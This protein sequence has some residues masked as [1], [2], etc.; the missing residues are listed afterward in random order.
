MFNAIIYSELNLQQLEGTASN[1][2][3][4]ALAPFPL[5]FHQH[6]LRFYLGLTQSLGFMVG[7]LVPERFRVNLLTGRTANQNPPQLIKR[8]LGDICGGSIQTIYGRI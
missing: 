1:R 7:P 4:H 5:K 6:A 8:D 2:M 3:N